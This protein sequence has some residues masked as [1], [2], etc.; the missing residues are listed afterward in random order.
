[1]KRAKRRFFK[2]IFDDFFVF[3][4]NFQNLNSVKPS[5]ANAH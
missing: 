2:G 3:S 1:M 5:F 4:N